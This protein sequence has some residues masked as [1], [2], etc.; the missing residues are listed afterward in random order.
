[1]IEN[2]NYA[3]RWCTTITKSQSMLSKLDVAILKNKEIWLLKQKGETFT[4]KPKVASNIYFHK[5]CLTFLL[6]AM[7]LGL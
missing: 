7:S 1:M 6:F 3:E 4:N 2:E 5:K